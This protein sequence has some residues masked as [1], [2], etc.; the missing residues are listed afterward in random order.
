[1]KEKDDESG[2]NV[3]QYQKRD[4]RCRIRGAVDRDLLARGSG[5]GFW[6]GGS[7]GCYSQ[8][9]KCLLSLYTKYR[10][11]SPQLTF[12]GSPESSPSSVSSES[13]SDSSAGAAAAAPAG[14]ANDPI[15]ARVQ[16][17]IK[18]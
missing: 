18:V 8:C 3:S 13:P 17:I 14:A 2:G 10:T 7:Q 11:P 15:S 5:H 16:H 12:Q 6:M 4:S 1:M 9:I